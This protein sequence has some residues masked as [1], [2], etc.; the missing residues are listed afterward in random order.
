MSEVNTKQKNSDSDADFRNFASVCYSI[1]NGSLNCGECYGCIK[2]TIPLDILG[3][4]DQYGKDI[5]H[6]CFK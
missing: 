2:T 6:R 5:Q 4:L 1:D 3:K